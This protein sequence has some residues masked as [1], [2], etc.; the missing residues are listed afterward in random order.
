M[1]DRLKSLLPG[2]AALALAIGLMAG[3]SKPAAACDLNAMTIGD[4]C[5]FAFD[6]CPRE[7]VRMNGQTLAV[8]E[9]Q[10]LFALIGYRYGGNNA[11]LFGVPDMRG[12]EVVGSGQGAGLSY[13]PIGTKRGQEV[14]ALS[15]AQTGLPPH[16]HTATFTGTGGGG[17]TPLSV[18]LPVATGNGN[19]S[20]V[21][22]G[23]TV[24]L[25]GLNIVDADG[26]VTYAG[27]YTTNTPTTQ[28]KIVAN[29]TGGGGGITGGTVTVAPAG[30]NPSAYTPTVPPQ[31]GLT[32]CIVTNGLYPN[33]P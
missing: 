25:A 31:L 33:R 20:T 7:F 9:Y 15:M 26:N 5:V 18:S 4:V 32:Y 12:R 28:G 16:T 21:T 10:A 1:Q 23:Q 17:G 11:D 6:W 22:S 2:G 27:P 13:L 3:N 14:V 24:S 8:R 29:A 19:A 30:A